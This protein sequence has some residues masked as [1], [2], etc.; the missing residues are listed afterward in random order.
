M[1][2]Q[3]TIYFD[4]ATWNISV[5]GRTQ[6]PAPKVWACFKLDKDLCGESGSRIEPTALDITLG[7]EDVK[8]IDI[9]ELDGELVDRMT[10]VCDQP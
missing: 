8:I 10:A 3:S 5:L 2:L 1:S 6:R 9:L 4:G 7:T